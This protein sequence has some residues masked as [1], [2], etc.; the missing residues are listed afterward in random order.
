MIYELWVGPMQI[1]GKDKFAE[2]KKQHRSTAGV[3]EALE[4]WVIIVEAAVWRMPQELKQTFNSADI[5]GS[6]NGKTLCVFDL[7]GNGFRL[8]AWVN[9][10]LSFVFPK[11][12]MDHTTY[13]KKSPLT[14][15]MYQ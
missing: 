4:N 5:I 13:D 8:V 1:I 11:D 6:R 12:F 14:L 3:S 2:W 9:F 7:K 10:K 15:D